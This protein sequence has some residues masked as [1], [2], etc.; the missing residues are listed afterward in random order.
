[1]FIFA[2]VFKFDTVVPEDCEALTYLD[3]FGWVDKAFVLYAT[4]ISN[5]Y[6]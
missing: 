5:S 4:I 6:P 1:M 2:G 3:S